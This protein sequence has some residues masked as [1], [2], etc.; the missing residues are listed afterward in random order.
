MKLYGRVFARTGVADEEVTWGHDTVSRPDKTTSESASVQ[1]TIPLEDVDIIEE[2]TILAANKSSGF[3]RRNSRHCCAEE[4]LWSQV[5]IC[6]ERD[7]WC[8]MLQLT[9]V[10]CGLY[11]CLSLEKCARTACRYNAR[12]DE[13][14]S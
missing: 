8:T 5:V 3:V 4:W 7:L 11:V 13:I 9:P 1:L 14:L 6:R 10:R 2:G 12:A